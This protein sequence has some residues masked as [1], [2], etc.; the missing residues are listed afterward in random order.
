MKKVPPYKQLSWDKT[1][2][3]S[4]RLRKLLTFGYLWLPFLTFGYTFSY[5]PLPF[6][7]FPH[8]SS[9]FLN[10]P[11]FSLPCLAFPYPSLPYFAFAH[12]LTD[13]LTNIIHYDLL[14]CLR[15][16]KGGTSLQMFDPSTVPQKL[17][18]FRIK[19]LSHNY[20][21]IYVQGMHAYRGHGET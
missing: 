10:L 16:Q 1:S 15:S 4:S 3:K 11:Y 20:F 14:G 13:R 7:T 8:L 18:H 5:L 19:V 9:P 6:L 21:L 12:K 17:T 2:L